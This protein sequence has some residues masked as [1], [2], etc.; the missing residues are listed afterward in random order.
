MDAMLITALI[1][2]F[3]V[4]WLLTY[5]WLLFLAILGKGKFTVW[6]MIPSTFM[7]FAC[8]FLFYYFT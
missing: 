8:S 2:V 3:F 7:G 4:G 5:N 6:A 1:V